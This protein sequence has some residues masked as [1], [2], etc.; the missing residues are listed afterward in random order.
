MSFMFWSST[1]GLSNF[2]L[3]FF[4]AV[5][6][7]AP[8]AL[9]AQQT[10]ALRVNTTADEL[11]SDGDC[12]LREALRAANLDTAVDACA[13]GSGADTIGLPAGTY[14][15]TRAGRN[16]NA[17]VT[18]DL[19]ITA[20]LTI[21]GAG[22]AVTIIDAGALDRVVENFAPSVTISGVTVTNGALDGDSLSAQGSGIQ[23]SGTLR[24]V[25][26]AVTGNL[27]LIYPLGLEYSAGGI[28][29]TGTLELTRGTIGGNE[30][31]PFGVGGLFNAGRATITD[32]SLEGNRGGLGTIYNVATLLIVDSR[33]AGNDITIGGGIFNEARGTMTVERTSI[34]GNS[35]CCE[36]S[37][38]G[39]GIYN[40]G[41]ATVANSLIDSNGGYYYGG[42]IATSGIMS[43]TN[44]TI[45][46]NTSRYSGGGIS[47]GGRVTI[48][49]STITANEAGDGYGPSGLAGTATVRNTIIAGNI[50]PPSPIDDE[51][52]DCG[53]VIS[54]GYNLIGDAR[55]CS[56]SGD[57]TGNL[58]NVD[59]Q[60]G[61]LQNNGGP[62]ATYAL[63]PGSPA[64]DKGAPQAPGGNSP[65]CAAADQRGVKRPNDGNGDG[66]ARCDIGAYEL[67]K[68]PTAYALGDANRLLRFDTAAPGRILARATISGLQAGE[69]LVGIEVRPSNGL[70]YALGSTSRVYR[71]DPTTGRATALGNGRFSP[72]LDGRVF[73]LDVDPLTDELH[74]AGDTGQ[75]L[76]IDL[77]S[78]AVIAVE[79]PLQYF[80]NDP[81][82]GR[83]P[84]IDGVA[85][86]NADQPGMYVLDSAR[87][88]LAVLQQGD[89]LY[90]IGNVGVP[91]EPLLGFDVSAEGLPFVA[92]RADDGVDGSVLATINL[93]TGKLQPLGSIGA[94]ETLRG[95]AIA[96]P[97]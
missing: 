6:G 49:N 16:E 84:A 47:A 60:L 50:A 42:G 53:F 81:A 11:N 66:T 92:L 7:A 24:L 44:S 95:L 51:E 70:L 97:R 48:A 21:S 15:L 76:R 78:G 62:T 2:L 29:N 59:P 90:T 30:G 74:V 28:V 18:G 41:N 4:L 5:A 73:G 13:A 19:D 34:V 31:Y 55:N 43:I 61:P 56:I 40:E 91:I 65:A 14:V 75:H 80:L 26:S 87:D 27:D 46:R 79:P 69:K 39:G 86:T 88:S 25:D 96:Q 37:S 83:T 63:I 67:G 35:A 38:A 64:I 93:R 20:P 17:A 3:V 77:D 58:L 89:E 54:Q 36:G 94:G 33:I 22:Q 8:P 12:S 57:T 9:P 82:F 68:L 72:T 71:V 1:G 23:N 85:F 52:P 45:S 10:A 32:S